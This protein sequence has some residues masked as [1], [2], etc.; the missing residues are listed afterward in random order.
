MAR[1]WKHLYWG[2]ASTLVLTHAL[3]Y[4]ADNSVNSTGSILQDLQ[5]KTV[6]SLLRPDIRRDTPAESQV[7]EA[8][9]EAV[10]TAPESEKTILIEKIDVQGVTLLDEKAVRDVADTY[11]H[12][13][14][15]FANLQALAEA[16]TKLYQAEGYATSRVYIPVQ[17]L[18][19]NTLILKALEGTVG[20]IT[21]V[22]GKHYKARSVT[23]YLAV[24]EGE[25]F[26]VN[27]LKRLSLIHISEPTRPY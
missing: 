10:K 24:E 6:P 1:C 4:G 7:Q 8:P 3:A 20:K 15:T 11:E 26:N 5:Q 22:P 14:N 23:P 18:E 2:L 16:L 9:K 27:K 13:E 12:K 19:N 17:K 25:P 21:V